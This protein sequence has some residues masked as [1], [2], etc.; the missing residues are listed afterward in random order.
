MKAVKVT[1]A[2]AV[3]LLEAQFHTLVGKPAV[4][5]LKRG[6]RA[7]GGFHLVSVNGTALPKTEKLGNTVAKAIA[8]I[9]T[10]DVPLYHA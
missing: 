10:V 5:V 8:H 3:S 2:D 6:H 7:N 9:T 4:I 1:R